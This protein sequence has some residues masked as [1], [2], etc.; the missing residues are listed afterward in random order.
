MFNVIQVLPNLVPILW[1][2]VISLKTKWPHFL[3]T[4]YRLNC[5]KY[6]KSSRASICPLV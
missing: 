2:L 6:R 1:I 4:R 3:P 5:G